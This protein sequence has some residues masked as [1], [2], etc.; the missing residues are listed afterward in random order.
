M[1][2][3]RLAL[4]GRFLYYYE[5][6][7]DVEKQV[8]DAL[9]E[10]ILAFKGEISCH[11]CT[12]DELLEIYSFMKYDLP[13]LFYVKSVTIHYRSSD[14]K[15]CTAVPKY[16]FDMESSRRMLTAMESRCEALL[17]SIAA[18]PQTDRERRI[19]D[20]LAHSVTYQDPQAPYSHE[21]AG[22]LLYGIGVCEGIAKAFKFLSDRAGLRA[23]V[24]VGTSNINGVDEGHAWNMVWLD[25]TNSFYH[26]DTTFDN[27]ISMGCLRYDYYNLS[28]E[29]M[30][31]GH[32]WDESYPD[33]SNSM[34][35]YRMMGV[36]FGKKS[37]LIRF[38]KQ[39]P[40]EC[41]HIV[42][43][44]PMFTEGK[45]SLPRHLLTLACNNIPQRR[46]TILSNLDRMIFQLNID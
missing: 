6:L 37:E 9:L 44:L 30:R 28:D 41:R 31:E 4:K 1:M 45:E 33:C 40:H 3:D 25:A 20:Y 12:C 24:V 34:E 38:L 27:T 23:L 5:R 35:Y 2:L 26:V 36:Y 46:L 15:N 8:Y 43:R 18:L 19:H 42:F 13:E 17:R 32:K 22:P 14:S 7:S 39:L 21:A 11:G 16:L 10:G 29:E